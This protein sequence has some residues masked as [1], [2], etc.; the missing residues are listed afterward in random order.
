MTATDPRTDPATRAEM[1][2]DMVDAITGHLAKYDGNPGGLAAHLGVT[3]H[4]PA[5]T[6]HDLDALHCA[7]HGPDLAA[8]RLELTAALAALRGP[9]ARS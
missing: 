8:Q 2:Q 7:C 9:V 1:A 5:P 4:N 6:A 3:T